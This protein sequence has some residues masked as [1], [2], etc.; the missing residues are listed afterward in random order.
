MSTLLTQTGQPPE[1][2][3]DAN[4]PITAAIFS[5]FLKC[6]TKAHLMATGERTPG[7]YFAH[8]EARI[9]SMYKAAAKR[10]SPI[11]GEVAEFLDFGERWRTLDHDAIAHYVDCET[12]VYNLAPPPHRTGGRHR[13][14]RHPAPLSPSGFYPGTS[15]A[16]PTASS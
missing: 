5:A 4:I 15:R 10:Q 9:S 6:S 7:T 14:I 16:F 2:L 8:I 1:L 11:G 12:A 3:V 13:K